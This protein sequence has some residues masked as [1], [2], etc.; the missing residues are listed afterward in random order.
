M[1]EAIMYATAGVALVDAAL[2]AA[3]LIVYARVYWRVK[4]PFTVGLMMF[5]GLFLVQNLIAAYAY[6]S[7]MALFS[8]AVQPFMLA[9]MALEALAL[10]VMLLFSKT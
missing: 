7:M 10:G 4:A 6:L 1:S 8:D 9:V 5:A 2:S 3:L